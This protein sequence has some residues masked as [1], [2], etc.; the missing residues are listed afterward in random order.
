MSAFMHDTAHID[1]LVHAGLTLSKYPIYYGNPSKSLT[2]GTA[3]EVGRML[4]RENAESMAYRYNMKDLDNPAD[5]GT[6]PVEYLGYLAQAD[7]YTYSAAARHPR[8]TAVQMLMALDSYE[9]QS[10]EHPEWEASEA[11]QFCQRLRSALIGALPGY[12]EAGTWTISAG[13]AGA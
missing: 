7:A 13:E 10:C 12:D 4:L 8:F 3:T 2:A 1:A 11:H 5:D 6:R 9:Y